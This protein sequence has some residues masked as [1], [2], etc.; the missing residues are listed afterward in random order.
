MNAQALLAMQHPH[1]VNT[2]FA[3]AHPEA[4]PRQHH[5]HGRQRLEVG[6]LEDEVELTL[7]QRVR[8]EAETEGVENGVLRRI[9]LLYLFERPVEQPVRIDCHRL[10]PSSRVRS[11][12]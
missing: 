8:P 3:I 9:G 10:P 1:P 6:L 11:R 5:R 4:R 2:A 7:I 12:V